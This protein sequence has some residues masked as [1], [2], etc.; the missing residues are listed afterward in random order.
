MLD[1]PEPFSAFLADGDSSADGID[2]AAWVAHL[3]G[4]EL[5]QITVGV[6]QVDPQHRFVH[7]RTL[8]HYLSSERSRTGMPT[9]DDANPT[10]AQLGPDEPAQ[11]G[12]G[13]GRALT[14]VA[15]AIGGTVVFAGTIGWMMLVAFALLLALWF[16]G[17]FVLAVILM[18]MGVGDT[19]AMIAGAVVSAIVV[20]S[21][22]KTLWDIE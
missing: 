18:V 19:A 4:W 6:R 1:T 7:P 5:E 20:G 17:M 10:V 12:S 9:L 11:A 14:A 13:L 8:R 15:H 22:S 2:D 3:H 21:L 16:G